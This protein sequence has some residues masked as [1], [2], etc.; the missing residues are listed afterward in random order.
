MRRLAF[1]MSADTAT[2]VFHRMAFA[3]G[4]IIDPNVIGIQCAIPT[5]RR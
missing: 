1:V 3:K 5:Q 4:A 2:P